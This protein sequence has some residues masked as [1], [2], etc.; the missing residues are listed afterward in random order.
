MLHQRWDCIAFLHWRYDVAELSR[1]LPAG[2]E[3]EEIDG[4][5]WVGMTPF[6]ARG[7]RMAGLPF[8]RLGDFPETNLRT[9]VR[10]RSGKRAVWFFSLEAA[11]AAAVAAARSLLGVPYHLADMDAQV[12]PARCRYVSR[13]GPGGTGHRIEVRPGPALQGGERAGLADALTARWRGL[14]PRAGR[15]LYVP[16]SHAPWPLHRAELVECDQDLLEGTGLPSPRGEPDVLW[17]PGVDAVI[18]APR[19]A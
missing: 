3:P 4:S 9:Y 14:V 7:T 16:I 5:A 17:S 6:V 8:A 13:R 10:T 12:S 19:L 18:G 11:S 1:R 2:L 15:R